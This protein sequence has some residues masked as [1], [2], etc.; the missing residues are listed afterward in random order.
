MKLPKDV[1]AL[2]RALVDELDLP[3]RGATL[4]RWMAHEVADLLL[5][6]DQAEDAAERSALVERAVRLIVHLWSKR[7]SL[8]DGFGPVSGYRGV[9]EVLRRLDPGASPLVRLG[10]TDE[11]REMFEMLN[12]CVVGGLLLTLGRWRRL[13]PQERDALDDDEAELVLALERSVEDYVQVTARF[14]TE[15]IHVGESGNEVGEEGASEVIDES[16]KV[17]G[18]RRPDVDRLH[19]AILENLKRMQEQLSRLLD[20]WRGA[21]SE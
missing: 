6:V 21:E 4:E 12:R 10:P 5:Q 19:A 14:D 8:P 2:G 3:A 15:F 7:W 13:T 18:Y 9:I 1:L 17:E 16:L 11:V 20:R